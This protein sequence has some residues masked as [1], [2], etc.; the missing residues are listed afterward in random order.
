MIL[1]LICIDHTL[2]ARS[3]AWGE[4]KQRK[5]PS[6]KNGLGYCYLSWNLGYVKL[7]NSGIGST[8]Q[9]ESD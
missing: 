9:Q 1:N 3:Q 5:I 8:Q 2:T 7:W 6:G 4:L